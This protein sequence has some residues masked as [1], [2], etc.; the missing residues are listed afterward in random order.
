MEKHQ[1]TVFA[2]RW[3]TTTVEVEALSLM[4]AECKALN[5]VQNNRGAYTFAETDEDLILS[6]AEAGDDEDDEDLEL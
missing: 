4:D 6:H 2:Q 3:V 5:E 1:V